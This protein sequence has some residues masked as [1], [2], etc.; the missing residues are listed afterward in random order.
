MQPLS[1]KAAH[2]RRSVECA[3]IATVTL[4]APLWSAFGGQAAEGT[5]EH[6]TDADRQQMVGAHLALMHQQYKEAV[7]LL[8]PLYKKAPYHTERFASPRDLPADT[9]PPG[10]EIE[11]RVSG[12]LWRAMFGDHQY[13]K[14]VAL[15]SAYR[16]HTEGE[17]LNRTAPGVRDMLLMMGRR[18]SDYPPTLALNHL[19]VDFSLDPL[20][21]D[22]MLFVPAAQLGRALGF[23][24]V[25][26]NSERI[27]QLSR[28]DWPAEFVFEE[29]QRG[30]GARPARAQ[31][32]KPPFRQEG[33]LMLAAT[34]VA[35]LLGGEAHWDPEVPFMHLI[36]PKVPAKR[37]EQ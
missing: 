2:G 21:R 10:V 6:W 27:V 32:E 25:T 7:A 31:L 37:A 3:L 26:E 30:V 22:E 17:P 16:F 5:T 4:L 19:W 28:T 1:R 35:K 12:M 29:G 20:L 9:L 15:H 34:D 33:R 18:V 23:E 14:C 11:S 13:T 8:I 36:I 24:T